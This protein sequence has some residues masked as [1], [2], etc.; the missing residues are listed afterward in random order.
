M[1]IV[2]YLLLTQLQI[3]D[4]ILADNPEKAKAGKDRRMNMKGIIGALAD[5]EVATLEL[6]DEANHDEYA[7][8]GELY[9]A[10]REAGQ[11]AKRNFSG[12]RTLELQTV[13]DDGIYRLGR[14]YYREVG[15]KRLW[16]DAD[17]RGSNP[18]Q[19]QYCTDSGEPEGPIFDSVGEVLI[20]GEAVPFARFDRETWTWK[21]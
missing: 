5:L 10:I 19:L 3:Y 11:V 8:Y 20:D 4:T 18:I 14:P 17:P 9:E 21:D 12:W 1:K 6:R 7:K 13:P 15:S 2:V 16:C